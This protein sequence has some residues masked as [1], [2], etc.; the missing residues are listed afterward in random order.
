[1]K[2]NITRYILPIIFSVSLTEIFVTVFVYD[3]NKHLEIPFL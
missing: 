2:Y 1:M 3:L